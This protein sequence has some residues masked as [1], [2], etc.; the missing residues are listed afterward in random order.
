MM[1]EKELTSD[2]G[3]KLKK[4]IQKAKK[5]KIVYPLGLNYERKWSQSVS[6]SVVS[7]FATS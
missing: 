4:K 7:F 6:Y 3:H 1:S 5:V 2:V